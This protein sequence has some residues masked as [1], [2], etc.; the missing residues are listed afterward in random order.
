MTDP[1]I[2]G[3]SL[4]SIVDGP[5]WT[6]AEAN[7]VKLGGHLASISSDS[8][9]KFLV[10]Q[11]DANSSGYRGDISYYLGLTD[12]ASKGNWVWS[13]GSSLSYSNW[14][15][16]EPQQSNGE[17]Y[18]EFLLVS[19]G[20]RTPGQWGDNFET[21][22]SGK[23]IAETPIVIRGD[24]AYA[25]VQG[26]SWEEAEA[27]AQ[28]L[29][30]HLVTINDA[31]ENQFVASNFSRSFRD[32]GSY[33]AWIGTTDIDH[34]GQWTWSSSESALYSNWGGAINGTPDNAWGG[35]D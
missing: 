32:L 1:V 3:N 8:E 17:D 2:R 29:G 23:G 21:I 22:G 4:Y 27:N 10:S 6:Q 11:Y 7:S 25:I 24:S 28:K 13:D 35:Q 16:G 15:S 34:K 9:N 33:A 30:G 20:P 19:T 5:S 12:T 14:S 26:P 18:S 31:A